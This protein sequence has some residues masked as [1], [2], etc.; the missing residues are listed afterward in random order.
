MA[1]RGKINHLRRKL[2]IVVVR[3]SHYLVYFNFFNGISQKAV[4]RNNIKVNKIISF[5]EIIAK[6][7]EK[8][9]FP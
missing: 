5:E 8:I 3:K 4:E 7:I 6:A 2:P 1:K 9:K